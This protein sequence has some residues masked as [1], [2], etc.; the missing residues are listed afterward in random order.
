MIVGGGLMTLLTVFI[1]GSWTTL[2][3]AYLGFGG[4]F[5]LLYIF[6]LRMGQSRPIEA[7]DEVGG[8]GSASGR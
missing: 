3:W 5:I 4:T 2:R 7:S 1:P 8:D 6:L